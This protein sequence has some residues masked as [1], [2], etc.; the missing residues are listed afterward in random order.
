MKCKK[1]IFCIELLYINYIGLQ[2][3]W[4]CSDNAFRSIYF[5]KFPQFLINLDKYWLEG[6]VEFGSLIIIDKSL[7]NYFYLVLFFISSIILLYHL[8][9]AIF[10]GYKFFILIHSVIHEIRHHQV[11]HRWS[12]IQIRHTLPVLSISYW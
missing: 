6:T 2:L 3:F 11:F 8:N 12:R 7:Y 1:D 5:K 9:T 4:L 10:N